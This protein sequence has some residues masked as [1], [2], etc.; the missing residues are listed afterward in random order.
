MAF[1]RQSVTNTQYTDS[2]GLAKD[3]VSY[4]VNRSD[5]CPLKVIKRAC[6][7]CKQWKTFTKKSADSY[8]E[9]SKPDDLNSQSIF[10][11]KMQRET[12]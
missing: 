7:L 1:V 3:V 9:V 2:K 5:F 11:W 10:N 12:R 4:F 8:T 6:S